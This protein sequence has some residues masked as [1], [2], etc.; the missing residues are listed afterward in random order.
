MGVEKS[1]LWGPAFSFSYVVWIRTIPQRCGEFGV[2]RGF[3]LSS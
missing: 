2:S 3:Y 1:G